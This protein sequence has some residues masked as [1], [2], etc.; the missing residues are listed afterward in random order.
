M[1]HAEEN[2]NNSGRH[3]CSYGGT[4]TM[5]QTTHKHGRLC[6]ANE[7][8]NTDCLDVLQCAH[9][10]GCALLPKGCFK[11]AAWGNVEMIQWVVDQRCGWRDLVCRS[12]AAGG[13][14]PTLKWARANHRPWDVWTCMEAAQS[15]HFDILP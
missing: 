7:S 3:L 15:G 14:L 12:A 5:A 13:S 9:A 4:S 6:F 8:P 10:N 11:A 2:V 1:K